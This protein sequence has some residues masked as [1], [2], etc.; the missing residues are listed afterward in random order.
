MVWRVPHFND[1]WIISSEH[2]EH[3]TIQVEGLKKEL[4]DSKLQAEWLE[5]ALVDLQE[6]GGGV[7][8][9]GHMLT[10]PVREAAT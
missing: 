6:G 9:P 10:E 8:R 3:S 5:G 7:H 4:A 1:R 2:F